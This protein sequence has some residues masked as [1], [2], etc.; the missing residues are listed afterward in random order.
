MSADAL[1]LVLFTDE[2]R[3]L[4]RYKNTESVLRLVRRGLLK[5]ISNTKPYRFSR[6]SVLRL[7]N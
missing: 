6:G 4:L 5:P 3:D 7:I 1:P 2:V